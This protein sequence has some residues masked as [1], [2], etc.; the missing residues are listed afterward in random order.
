MSVQ[1]K[2][3]EDL[4]WDKPQVLLVGAPG[5]G[6]TVAACT[7]SR[8]T[9]TEFPNHTAKRTVLEDIIFVQ[10]EPGA[11]KSLA[12]LGLVV[13]TVIDLSKHSPNTKFK[14]KDLS[15]EALQNTL[16]D[17][18]E[19]I[20]KVGTSEHVVV[21]DS[22]STLDSMT[23]GYYSKKFADVA[24][25]DYKA[26]LSF[27][28]TLYNGFL[29]LAC[30]YVLI[31][32]GNVR[33]PID[34]ADSVAYKTAKAKAEN[35]S[36]K[37]MP[38]E[39]AISGSAKTFYARLVDEMYPVEIKASRNKG[40]TTRERVFRPLGSDIFEAKSRFEKFLRSEEPANLNALFERIKAGLAAQ[41]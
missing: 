16:V 9:P 12:S 27:H 35:A 20:D 26:N 30:G 40:V 28:S 6:K 11:T 3:S 34:N 22:I 38:G 36:G 8:F 32:H 2:S 31:S 17:T 24:Y 19:Y 33:A 29:S 39:L 21:F 25:G 37:R 4:T 23:S 14:P 13:P 1:V 15:I 5:V 18:F 7:A 10:F 41:A